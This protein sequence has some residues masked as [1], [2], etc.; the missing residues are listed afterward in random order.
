MTEPFRGETFELDALFDESSDA[1]KAVTR[2][3]FLGEGQVGTRE[4]AVGGIRFTN[5]GRGR[6]YLPNLQSIGA[7]S[8]E[9]PTVTLVSPAAGSLLR[10]GDAAVYLVTSATPIFLH[11]FRVRVGVN[12]PAA[13]Q[14]REAAY[15]RDDPSGAWDARYAGSSVEQ[16]SATQWRITLRRKTWPAGGIGILP[17]VSNGGGAAT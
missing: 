11:A 12:L 3:F 1:A 10:A 16:L 4:V 14:T 17:L 9:P 5:R 2:S 7:A 8:L 13:E 15:D 6:V